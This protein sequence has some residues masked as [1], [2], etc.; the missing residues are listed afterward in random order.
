MSRGSFSEKLQKIP[1]TDKIPLLYM[2]Q[3]M[4]SGLPSPDFLRHQKGLDSVYL[5][6]QRK[7]NIRHKN[8]TKC[9]GPWDI[10]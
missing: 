4:K 8:I 10:L 2:V 1:Q 9:A 5:T 3:S 6:S 7:K